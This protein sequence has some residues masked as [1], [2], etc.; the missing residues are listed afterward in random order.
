MPVDELV[1]LG[2]HE[3]RGA[4][5]LDGIADRI[6]A[7]QADV[8][9]V[10]PVE[11]REQVVP[12]GV[13]LD[14][15]VD[16]LVGE[17]GPDGVNRAVRERHVV[18]RWRRTRPIEDRLLGGARHRPAEHVE[19]REEHRGVIGRGAA[20]PP[21]DELCGVDRDVIDDQI[22]HHVDHGAE[23]GHVGPRAESGV[24]A[25][26]VDRVEA[27]VAAVDRHVE[28]KDVHP[29]ECPGERAA[30][31]A[32]KACE[33]ARQSVRVGDQLRLIAHRSSAV[34][35]IGRRLRRGSSPRPGS[36]HRSLR[37]RRAQRRTTRSAA[38]GC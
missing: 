35:R 11:D 19:R 18:E 3:A 28:R 34:S 31:G 4:R 24:D 6:E 30:Q 5:A 10:E 12:P 32:S 20:Q 38:R 15:D 33:V 21:V 16:L 27:G 13:V 2:N 29:A 1:R 25:G 26:V 37:Q 7:D 36:P 22:S 9:L 8:S 17:C 23:F 14:I